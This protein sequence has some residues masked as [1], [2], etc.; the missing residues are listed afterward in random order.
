MS[1]AGAPVCRLCGATGDR[2]LEAVDRNRE[3]DDRRFAYSRCRSCRTV[4][5]ENVPTD[6]ERYYPQDYHGVP[7]PADLRLRAAGE[8]HK[9]D[10]LLEHVEPG[11][12]VEVGPS[13]GAFAF[14]A[15]AAGFEV[16]GIE[17]DPA[18]CDYLRDVVG[19]E[20][21]RSTAPQDVLSSLPPS[22]AIAMYHVIEHVPRPWAVIDAAAASLEPG[23]VLAIALP[24]PDS[25]QFRRLGSRWAHLDAPRH[26]YLIPLET[27]TSHARSAGLEVAAVT[28]TD[29]FGRH[30]NRWGWEYA[31]R[32]RPA[33]APSSIVTVAA[34]HLVAAALAPVE[35]RGLRGCAYTVLLRRPAAV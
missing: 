28:T 30:C 32:R 20:A 1:A 9:V 17:M 11:R 12:L 19:V 26:Q 6:I 34:S 15:K 18:C 16:T 24:N 10:L 4:Q 35:R 22:R 27:L 7:T 23:G 21:I 13:Y 25:L 31:M 33:A 14:A 2:L 29:P 8:Q 5:L 3:V